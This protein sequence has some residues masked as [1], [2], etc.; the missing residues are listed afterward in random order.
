MQDKNN[1]HS[2]LRCFVTRFHFVDVLLKQQQ[3]RSLF[4]FYL[5]QMQPFA[6]LSPAPSIGHT[7]SASFSQSGETRDP[8]YE[9]TPFWLWLSAAAIVGGGRSSSG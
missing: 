8:H 7:I 6:T 9:Q 1:L 4:T 5:Q 2:L 3:S